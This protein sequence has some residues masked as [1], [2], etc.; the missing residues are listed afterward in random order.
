MAD[1][2]IIWSPRSGVITILLNLVFYLF[3]CVQGFGA[4]RARGYIDGVSDGQSFSKDILVA[5]LKSAEPA[6]LMRE[7]FNNSSD[8]KMHKNIIIQE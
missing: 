2:G 7:A 3:G 6:E 1:Y 4:G 5:A 8:G